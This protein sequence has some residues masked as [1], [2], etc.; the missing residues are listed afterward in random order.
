MAHTFMQVIKEAHKTSKGEAS[1]TVF[2]HDLGL[3]LG[4]E[5]YCI[6]YEGTCW[7]FKEGLFEG[8]R[9]ERWFPMCGCVKT[10]S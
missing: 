7:I 2:G 9:R 5:G 10:R 4:L 8:G 1:L 3:S 6:N